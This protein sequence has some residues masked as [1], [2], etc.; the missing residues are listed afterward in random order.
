[1]SEQ[2]RLDEV[3]VIGGGIMGAGIAAFFANN[4][5]SAKIFDVKLELAEEAIKQLSDPNAKIPL[6][7]STKRAK[8]IRAFSVEDYEKELGSADMIVEVVPEVM[9]LKKKVFQQIDANRKKGS[10]VATNTSGLSVGQMVEDCSEDMQKHFLGTHYFNPVRFLPLVELI[11]APKTPEGLLLQLQDW[12]DRVG[13]NPIIGKDTP[14]FVANRVGIFMMM[15]TL[16]LMEKFGLSIEEVDMVTGPPLGNPKTATFRLSDMVGIDTLVHAAMNSYESCPDDESRDDLKPPDLLMQMVERKLFGSKT[17]KGFYT[18]TRD[19]KFLTLDPKTFEYRPQ[20]TP[21]SDCVRYAKT[22][23]TPPERI[24]A[25]LTYGDDDRVSQFSRELVLAASAYALNRVGEIADDILTIDNAL[26]WGFAKEVGPIEILDHIG[27]DRA[28]RMMETSGIEV[29]ALLHE[30]IS[31]TGRFYESHPQGGATYF[32]IE[33]K[34][35]KSEPPKDGVLDISVLKNSGK[36]VR[37]NVNARL[38]DL[39]DEVLLCEL[40]AK[41]VPTMNPVDDYIISMMRQAKEICDSG[42]FKALVISNQAANFCAGA[43]LQLILELAKA[44]RWKE[45]ESVSKELQDINLALFHASFPVVTA[46]H[47][48]TLGGGLE[49]TYSG[50]KRVTYNELYCGLVEVGVGV[51]PAGGGCL[52]LLRQLQQKMAR[53]NPGPMPPVMQAFDLIGFGRVSTSASDAIDKGLL[54]RESTILAYSKSRQIAEAKR[55]ALE[56]LEGFEPIELEELILPGKEGYNVMEDTIDGFARAA[57]I[58]AHSAKIAKH[59]A[60][61]LTGGELA[62]IVSPVSEEY[63]LDLEREA[64]LQLCGEPMTQERM[65]HMLKKGKPLIN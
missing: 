19:K 54:S 12:F 44:G 4:D 53:A 26:K 34:H 1:M 41:M 27:L 13:K 63:V 52:Q 37:E 18:R 62:S 9:S 3:A 49:I 61:V 46:P 8:M 36:I 29:P 14:N 21:K 2:L 5:I 38:I 60:R 6:L 35:M 17:K 10:I 32:D 58:T 56:M 55:V 25:M 24:V 33:S 22:F 48:M 31:T 47:G 7:Y 40:D 64:F 57:K 51:V 16:R 15:K 45:I 59:Q 20:T 43:Q 50:Q 39:A 65:A 28:A 11:P 42:D 23:S 30:A